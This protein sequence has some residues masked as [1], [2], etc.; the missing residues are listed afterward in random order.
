MPVI[1]VKTIGT[2]YFSVV[3]DLLL[4][5]SKTMRLQPQSPSLS[6]MISENLG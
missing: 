5:N 3:H 1:P 6:L 2:T 4:I